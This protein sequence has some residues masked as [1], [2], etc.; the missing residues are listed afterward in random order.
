MSLITD[1]RAEL[2]ELE[3]NLSRTEE[4]GREIANHRRDEE[5]LTAKRDKFKA[6]GRKPVMVAVPDV[7]VPGL[8]QIA[9][10][11]LPSA[12]N[13]EELAAGVQAQLD[14]VAASIAALEAEETELRKRR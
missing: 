1:K 12:K 3:Q 11:P 5:R 8:G 7:M 14:D 2:A 4:I 13:G 10:A 9:M 6:F